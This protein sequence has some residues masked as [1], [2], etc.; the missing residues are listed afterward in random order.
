M[1]RTGRSAP[2]SIR[3][4]ATTRRSCRALTSV[5]FVDP[6]FGVDRIG[7]ETRAQVAQRNPLPVA[8]SSR[9]G[10]RH[11][12]RRD[13]VQ[14]RLDR[15]EMLGSGETMPERHGP[16]QRNRL[17]LG[18]TPDLETAQFGDMAERAERGGEIA[19]QRADIGALAD[20]GLEIGVIGVGHA[21]QP[22]F[23]DLDRARR[24]FGSL[25]GAGQRIGA[26]SGNFDRRI[27]RRA[28]QD[29]PGKMRQRR[30]DRSGIRPR[31]AFGQHVAF[32]IV[33]IGRD[34]PADAEA[35]ALAPGGRE[36]RG[37]CRLAERQRQD[38]GGERVERPGMP[39]LRAGD[40]L[41]R[42]RRPAP[43]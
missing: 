29:R 4:N 39:D 12:E 17:R 31:R 18:E 41:D 38:A 21:E 24:Q 5:S 15:Q 34:A 6:G 43:R 2:S 35:I 27:G 40:A 23:G 20:F 1:M 8:Q 10:C 30:D 22:Q 7:G 19:G 26:A 32:P 28:L 3:A 25:A 37:L 42:S 11:G 33:G 13:V 14:R 9:F 36:L 16:F